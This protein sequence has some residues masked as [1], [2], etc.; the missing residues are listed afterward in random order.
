MVAIRKRMLAWAR[1]GIDAAG[2]THLT[3]SQQEP[4]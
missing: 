4:S 2:Q 3:F 1:I